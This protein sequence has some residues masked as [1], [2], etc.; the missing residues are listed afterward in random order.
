[1]FADTNVFL[2]IAT[3]DGTWA[4]WSAERLLEAGRQDD[5]LTNVVVLGELSRTFASLGAA[6]RGLRDLAVTV[7]DLNDEPAF[8][9]GQRF[10]AYR[11]AKDDPAQRVLPDFL[12]GAHALVLG[13]A[14]ITRDTAVYRRYFPDLP[15][16]TPETHPHG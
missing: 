7:L 5:V 8:L 12:I 2:D 1:M 13:R 4:S 11:R 10:L 6:R 3:D 16:I 15:L 9:A 14:L